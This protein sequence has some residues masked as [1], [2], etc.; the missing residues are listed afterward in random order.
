[1][2]V[3]VI[4]P[5]YNVE[6][7]IEGCVASVAGQT[8]SDFDVIVVDDCSEDESMRIFRE[9]IRKYGFPEERVTML[10]HEKNRGLS[11]AR[12]TGIKASKA[13]YVYFLDSDDTI[14]FDCIEQLLKMSQY[15]GVSVDMVVGN[16]RF[17]GPEIGCPHVN[18]DTGFLSRKAYIKA[19][20]KELIY[21]MAW[22][23]LVRREF[24]LE[25]DLFFEEG[26]IHEDTLWNFQ[27]LQYIGTV[28]VTKAETYI[29]LVRQNSIQ[30]S[31]NFE[32]HF[33]ANSYI[34]GR[35]AEIMF[36]CSLKRNKYVYNF[37]ENE[38][39]RH[40]YDC[41]RSNNMQLVP[42]LYR[43]IRQKPHYKPLT[44]LL[45]FGYHEGTLRKILKR[46]M[47]Y[48]MSYEEGLKKFENL[49]NTL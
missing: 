39:V 2:K 24:I 7:Y 14:T 46:D 10:R 16:Y 30:S 41:W 21:P 29:Y 26:L 33:K 38:K 1:M 11:A 31:Q 40:L 49:P 8:S 44:A 47:H 42:E 17:D 6:Q 13:E 18:V 36:G 25:H 48:G 22:N 27:M 35:I 45:L 12:N 20:C 43:I 37:V 32:R 23:R 19:Y 9:S 4:I 5:V 34:V 28:G 3:S 15:K